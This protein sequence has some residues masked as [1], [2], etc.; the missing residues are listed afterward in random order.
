LVL[1]ITLASIILR[2]PAP[3]TAV[4]Q[5]LVGNWN[6]VDLPGEELLCDV[7][8][9]AN[10]TFHANDRQFVGQWWISSGQLHIKYRSGEWRENW[11]N[12]IRLWNAMR[13]GT[14]HTDIHFV[15]DRVELAK[16]GEPTFC[17]LIGLR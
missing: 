14:V 7:T 10:R 5:R 11:L 17:E 3:L 15:G 2:P 16:P 13:S 4:E 6:N 9:T 1:L 12:P 8:F